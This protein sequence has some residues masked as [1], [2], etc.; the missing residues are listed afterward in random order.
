MPPVRG[1]KE[2]NMGN[3]IGIAH[4]NTNSDQQNEKDRDLPPISGLSMFVREG[5]LCWLFKPYPSFPPN[6]SGVLGAALY[7]LGDPLTVTPVSHTPLAVPISLWCHQTWLAGKSPNYSG[8]NMGKPSNKMDQNGLFS[9]KPFWEHLRIHPVGW[10]STCLE[11]GWRDG[12]GK[13]TAPS[14]FLVVKTV[15]FG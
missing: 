13:S 6:P 14:F 7:H 2:T 12:A 11:I 5:E 3:R 1:I 8:I 15:F 9:S 4:D 10:V